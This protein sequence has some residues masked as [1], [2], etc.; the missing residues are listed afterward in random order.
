MQVYFAGALYFLYLNILLH[1]IKQWIQLRSYQI[2]LWNQQ[3]IL[4]VRIWNMSIGF[5]LNFT[6]H[7]TQ[8]TKNNEKMY[9]A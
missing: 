3:T 1:I 9:K 6:V 7:Y 4:Y 5:R 8:N 2:S